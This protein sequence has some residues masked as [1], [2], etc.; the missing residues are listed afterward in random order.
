MYELMQMWIFCVLGTLIQ[1]SPCLGVIFGGL[2]LM[3]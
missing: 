3:G 2:V 1:Y